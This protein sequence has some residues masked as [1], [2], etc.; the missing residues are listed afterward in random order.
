MRMLPHM[1]GLLA[2]LKDSR[3]ISPFEYLVLGAGILGAGL[4]GLATFEG[5]AGIGLASAVSSFR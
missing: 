1:I 5:P 3:G 4:T 2:A